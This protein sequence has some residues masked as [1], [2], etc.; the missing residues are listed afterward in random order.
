ME[1]DENEGEGSKFIELKGRW[2]YATW[3]KFDHPRG[4][5]EGLLTGGPT[6]QGRPC[7]ADVQ[8][9]DAHCKHSMCAGADVHAY[10][11]SA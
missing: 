5:K 10:A 9:M 6:R 2:M 1:V 8:G 11:H 3:H 4:N 7:P